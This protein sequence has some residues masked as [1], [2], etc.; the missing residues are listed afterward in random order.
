[1]RW[2]QNRVKLLFFTGNGQ[3]KGTVAV[4]WSGLSFKIS[5]NHYLSN[6]ED[7]LD[8]TCIIQPTQLRIFNI[9]I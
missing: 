6:K 3:I 8:F 7:I 1:M 2:E 4:I 9:K 5:T